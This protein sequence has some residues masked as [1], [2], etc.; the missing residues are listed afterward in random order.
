MSELD[1]DVYPP[2]STGRGVTEPNLAEGERRMVDQ[3]GPNLNRIAIW[4]RQLD[5]IRAG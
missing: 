1:S 2:T 3:T 4:L 5:H